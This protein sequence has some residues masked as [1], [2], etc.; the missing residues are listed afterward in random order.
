MANYT[1][2]EL[3]FMAEQYSEGFPADEIPE[4]AIELGSAA[5]IREIFTFDELN[6]IADYLNKHHIA[7]TD[8]FRTAIMDKLASDQAA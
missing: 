2:E 8:Y 4:E 6:E 3:S 1:D 5:W 7:F